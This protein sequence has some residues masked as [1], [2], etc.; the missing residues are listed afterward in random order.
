MK[1]FVDQSPTRQKSQILAVVQKFLIESGS[2]RAARSVSA[3]SLL[4]QDLGIGSLERAELFHRVEKAFGIQLPDSLMIDAKRIQDVMDAVS[5][6][7]PEEFVAA[8]S[9]V[10]SLEAKETDPSGGN[11]LTEV[12]H[13]Y[14]EKDPERP[15][16]YLQNEKGKEEIIRYGKLYEMGKRVAQG[17]INKGLKHGETVAIMLPT[18][19]EFFY[20]F[21][22]VLLAG[23]IPVPIYPPF[24][25][26]QIEEYAKREAL[27]LRNAGVRVLITFKRAETLSKLLQNFIP[28]LLEVTT[29]DVLI[30]NGGK[31]SA[32]P[33][34]SADLALI[35][36]TSGS[37]GNPKGVLLSHA[38]LLAN[39]KTY[40]EGID[41]QPTDVAVSWL[42]LYH[43]M[44]L[45]GAWL[46]SLYYGVPLTLLSPLSFLSRPERWL[47]AIHYHRATISAGPNFAYELCIK[48]IDDEAIKGLDLSSWR[49]AFNG[50]EMI[51]A[52]TMDRFAKR[53]ARYGFQKQ[54]FFPAYGLAECSLALTFPPLK[55]E[56]RVDRIQRKPFEKEGRAIPLQEDEK[57]FY[58][59]VS[60]GKSV[61]GH[62]VR[63]VNE[64]NEPV[65]ERWV[66]NIQFQ[67]PSAMQGYYRN[68]E[69][70]KAIYHDGWWD[71][72]DL[73]YL[74]DGELF[75]TGR[76]KD[77]IIKA[78]RNYYPGEIEEIASLAKGVRKGCVAAFGITD[79][80]R[81]TERLVIVAEIGESNKD[82]I[83]DEI[84]KKVIAQ[85]GIPPDEVILVSPHTVPKTSSGKL[86]RSTCKKDYLDG[87]LGR[88][89]IP[90]RL[91]MVKL[92]S[93]VSWQK[94]KGGMF[95]SGRF[96]FSI[97]VAIVFLITF[98]P[99]WL[100]I[101]LS[102]RK[103]AAKWF[104][105]WS[106]GIFRLCFCPI[107]VKGH[108]N[109]QTEKPMIYI[110][111]HTSYLDIIV[112]AGILPSDCNFIAKKEL[113]RAPVIKYFMKKFEY[114]TVD[115]VDFSKSAS[116]AKQIEESLKQGR[117]VII[118]PEGTFSY[119]TGVR[120]FKSGAFKVAAETGIPICPVAIKGARKILRANEKLLRPYPMHVTIGEAL[121]VQSGDW[122]EIVRLRES[123]RVWIA[124]HS[125]EQTVDL[126]VAG[127]ALR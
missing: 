30:T 54:A 120:P 5:A 104:R 7:H 113:L 59:F 114:I 20:A 70:T 92:F 21:F 102:S 69:A 115:R 43:D 26:D 84:V 56:P 107:T 72:G 8:Q 79:E 121:R 85:L 13:L 106:R 100:L 75:I 24:R 76:L 52:K 103:Q 89:G 33:L 94:L 61:R 27:I 38:N 1:R 37:T 116:D 6:A 32:T 82:G 44:G 91:Q 19:P 66:G 49:L 12:L 122:E 22:G 23:A 40:G 60:C 63:V 73:G 55:R 123:A 17:L 15:H 118:F 68:P 3:A 29:V 45:I 127:V 86:R 47:W 125:G 119:A 110:S 57:N 83:R 97:Y 16:I 58:E 4:E 99:A 93:Q 9:E 46:G 48:K 14:A 101:S 112:L 53:F 108:A 71:T 31:F 25:V 67:G 98:L 80:V 39:I 95:Q 126:I 78:G 41:I 65:S 87:K 36:Y 42:P 74:A 124:E 96:L 50:A 2:D 117:S 18:S 81:G 10:P 109:L 11:T 51:Y 62:D 90:S 64:K 35:Q 88:R 77:L 34:E 28:S 111:N 105:A